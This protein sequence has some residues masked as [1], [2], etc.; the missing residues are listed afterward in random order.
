VRTVKN[1]PVPAGTTPAS[2][3]EMGKRTFLVYDNYEALLG[4]NC[5]HNYAL[6]VALLS[7]KLP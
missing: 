2:I 5:S 1:Q 6:S 7:D 4:Y 3:V